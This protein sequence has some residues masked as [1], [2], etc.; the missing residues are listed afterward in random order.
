MSFPFELLAST[1]SVAAGVLSVVST[2]YAYFRDRKNEKD[3]MAKAQESEFEAV[4]NSSDINV[5]GT[6]LDETLGQ[7]NIHE[8]TA[9]TKVGERVNK[10]LNKIQSFVG[11]KEHISKE[12]G[13]KEDESVAEPGEALS[14]E[15]QT[16]IDELRTGERWNALAR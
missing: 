13:P 5:L 10:Y 8:Y 16:I 12:L 14:E 9:S 11:T 2:L 3:K 1:A 6:Y 4:L 15:F 7:F